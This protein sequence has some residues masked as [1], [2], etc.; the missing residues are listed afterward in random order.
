[1]SKIRNKAA[2]VAARLKNIARENGI[3]YNAILL[4]YMQERFLYRLSVSPYADN[5]I[6]KGGL[7]LFSID[8]LKSRPT[9]DMDF[10]AWNIPNYL[11]H[12]HRVVSAVS[13]LSCDDGLSFRLE[14]LAVEDIVEHGTYRG[15]RAGITCFLGKSWKR[16]SID[17][18]FGD[19]VV[20]GP[21]DI[22]YPVLLDTE[23]PPLIKAYSLESVIAEKFE[24]MIKLSFINSRMKDFYDI[25]TLSR[26]H[27]FEGLVLQEA[28]LETFRRRG[29]PYEGDLVIFRGEFINSPDKQREWGNYL[30]RIKGEAP[31]SFID[32]MLQI[33]SF[34]GPIFESICNEKEFF[35]HWNS[36]SNHWSDPLNDLKRHRL[37]NLQG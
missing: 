22:M 18:G 28:I 27:E 31:S 17:I 37:T 33:K 20:P 5:F 34:L 30:R 29:T 13:G 15:V 25:Y 1:M 35:P 11:D 6:L 14:D 8:R 12:I 19:A 4:L 26:R 32:A 9:V 23:P 7:L 3:D 2:S 36:E 24:A 21:T 16:L 10:L